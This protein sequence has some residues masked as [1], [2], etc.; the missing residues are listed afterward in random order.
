MTTSISSMGMAPKSTSSPRGSSH[1][2]RHCIVFS[3]GEGEQD[4]IGLTLH[5]LSPLLSP[6]SLKNVSLEKWSSKKEG[7]DESPSLEA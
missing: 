5:G 2:Q 7:R 1:P 6:N 3:L 4:W